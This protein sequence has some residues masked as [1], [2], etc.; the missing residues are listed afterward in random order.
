MSEKEL[1][2]LKEVLGLHLK[3]SGPDLF[4]RA[5]IEIG[6]Y[7]LSLPGGKVL[8]PGDTF[9]FGPAGAWSGPTFENG[10]A[11]YEVTG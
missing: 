5:L 4:E 8:R 10:C 9:T 11:V 3:Q 6:F 1:A 2:G 7:A